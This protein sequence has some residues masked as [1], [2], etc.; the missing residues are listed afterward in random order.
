M[1]DILQRKHYFWSF[2]A[3]FAIAIYG[4]LVPFQFT[5]LPWREAAARFARTPFLSLAIESRSDF[6]ANI[7]L[8][9]PL[10]FC[11]MGLMLVDRRGPGLKLAWAAVVAVSLCLLSV[12]IEFT[13]VFFPPRTVSQNDILAETIG[14]VIGVVL[15]LF[16]G[17]VATNWARRLWSAWD[18]ENLVTVL[19]PKYF[20]FLVLIHLMP[21]DLTISP[22]LIYRK[23]EAGRIV[24]VPFQSRNWPETGRKALMQLV[25]YAPL[26][27][28][29]G[30]LPQRYRHCLGSWPRILVIGLLLAGIME[31]LQIFVY[32]RGADVT[33]ALLGGASVFSGWALGRLLVT[34]GWQDRPPAWLKWAALAIWV[35]AALVA[36]WRPF[37]FTINNAELIE[38][39]GQVGLVPFADYYAG[40]DYN[41]FDQFL[42]KALLFFPLGVILTLGWRLRVSGTVGL[43]LLAAAM[44]EAGQLMLP[45]R[46]ASVS[47]VLVLT[48]GAW[49]GAVVARRF[50][51]R[52]AN[53]RQSPR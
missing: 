41:S 42:H 4:S 24:L 27:V 5:P 31:I 25:Y 28:L 36:E 3:F 29:L 16:V 10:G 33:D 38:R 14:G 17:Q 47:D 37:N 49:I 20:L 51:R 19:L 43:A 26:G 50:A 30:L 9:I 34:R 46:H 18:R 22:A 40:T 13:Q 21:L 52:Q 32:T 11:A 7:L 15:W 35:V 48:F 6:V 12:A 39:L 1:A 8:F 2:I 44:L 53:P 23:F 45:K